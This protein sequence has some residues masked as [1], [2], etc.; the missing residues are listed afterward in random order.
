MKCNE[1]KAKL[2]SKD[3]EVKERTENTIKCFELVKDF[4]V[5]KL[6]E[7]HIKDEFDDR[8]YYIHPKDVY[9]ELFKKIDLDVSKLK[10]HSM[11]SFN[12]FDLSIIQYGPFLFLHQFDLEADE[13]ADF[14]KEELKQH[15]DL[16]EFK[17]NFDG[18]L[19]KKLIID[20]VLKFGFKH[21]WIENVWGQQVKTDRFIISRSFLEKKCCSE[22]VK[23]FDGDG[24]L[25]DN[26]I[27]AVVIV[28][29]CILAFIY[30]ILAQV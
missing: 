30:F 9:D 1:L 11:F 17:K 28:A 18:E 5:D 27:G 16:G 7:D 12:A 4:V 23:P 13:A 10:W 22:Q 29:I 26:L 19:F 15:E 3:A 20:H 14:M 6:I 2:A 21:K 24:E 25:N 8:G